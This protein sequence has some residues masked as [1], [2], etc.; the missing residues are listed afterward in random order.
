MFTAFTLAKL[1]YLQAFQQVVGTCGSQVPS[2]TATSL[3][4][5]SCVQKERIMLW[6]YPCKNEKKEQ[7][8]PVERAHVTNTE[9]KGQQQLMP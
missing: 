7:E 5:V 6:P 8:K 3:F 2:S 9:G 4:G 1:Y